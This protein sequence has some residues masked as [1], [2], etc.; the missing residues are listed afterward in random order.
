MS[1]LEAFFKLNNFTHLLFGLR[2]YGNVSGLFSKISFKNWT[3]YLG[4]AMRCFPA[5]LSFLTRILSDSTSP[6]LMAHWSG[7]IF[8]A[9]DFRIS[10]LWKRSTLA[11]HF[12][13]YLCWRFLTAAKIS[14]LSAVDETLGDTSSQGRSKKG[15]WNRTLILYSEGNARHAQNLKLNRED[16]I[17]R[18]TLCCVH[19]NG[20]IGYFVR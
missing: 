5:I 1:K 8:S 18:A 6:D 10:K 7:L 17:S 12:S 2:N 13:R 9:N 3:F 4:L 16:W 14:R 11:R 20:P 19:T 15:S